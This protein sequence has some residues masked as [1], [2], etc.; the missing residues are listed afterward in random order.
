MPPEALILGFDTSAAHCAAA[1]LSGDRL[2]VSRVE[3]M[4]KGQAERLMPLLEEVLAE[5]GIG[6]RDLT[7]LAVCTGPGNFTGVRIA[8]ATARGLALGLGVPAI[9]VTVL[10]ARAAG[11]DWPVTVVEDARRG[12]VYVQHFPGGAAH[13]A[14]AESV[15]E[16][17]VGRDLPPRWPVAEAVARVAAGRLGAPH[18]RPAPFYLRE[19]DAALPSEPPPVILP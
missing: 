7:A 17:A 8:V 10:E 15:G 14:L 4:E 18:P 16:A 3:P 13:L 2:L 12:E 11:L 9:G 5:G 6:W 19:A 1:L